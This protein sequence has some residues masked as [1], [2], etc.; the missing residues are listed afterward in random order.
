MQQPHLEVLQIQAPADFAERIETAL[1]ALPTMGVSC[2]QPVDST[3]LQY[4]AYFDS[5]DDADR[6]WN[7]LHLQSLHTTPTDDWTLRRVSMP[8]TD[9]TESWKHHFRI[10]HVTERIVIR[11]SWEAY[12]PSPGQIVLAIDP[13]MSFGTGRHET[14]RACIRMLDALQQQGISGPF[15]DV[16]TGSGILAMAAARLGY[17]P[18]YACDLDPDA[19][20]N[21]RENLAR[22]EV[23]DQIQLAIQDVASLDLRST[24]KV[25]AANILAPVLIEHAKRIVAPVDPKDGRLL[26]AGILSTQIPDVAAAYA[27]LGWHITRSFPDG[28]WESLLLQR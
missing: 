16:G 6:A 1:Q 8:P 23:Q 25:V 10:E 3:I 19:I 11:P 18:I 24:Y 13:G 7:A 26:L 21:A 20:A 27:A 28:E 5:H 15:L 17:A 22:N 2:W 12:T 4:E 9:W 14:T